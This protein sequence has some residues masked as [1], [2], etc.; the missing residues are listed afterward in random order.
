MLSGGVSGT[1][2]CTGTNHFGS[3]RENVVIT[4]VSVQGML[5]IMH[6]QPD[7][8]IYNIIVLKEDIA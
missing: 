8:A 1:Y 5:P 6:M 2:T 4:I 7:S 3:D